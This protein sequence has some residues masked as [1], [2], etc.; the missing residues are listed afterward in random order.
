[1]ETNKTPIKNVN[2]RSNLNTNKSHTN[3]INQ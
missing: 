1:M 3:L 2:S